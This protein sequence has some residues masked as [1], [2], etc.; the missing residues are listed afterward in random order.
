MPT[1]ALRQLGQDAQARHHGRR[2][3]QLKTA[4]CRTG[5]V[6]D[7]SI[8]VRHAST[9]PR[10]LQG[11]TSAVRLVASSHASPGLLRI[12]AEQANNRRQIRRH[13]PWQPALLAGGSRDLLGRDGRPLLTGAGLARHVQAVHEVVERAPVT[14]DGGQLRGSRAASVGCIIHRVASSVTGRPG[15]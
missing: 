4:G 15:R 5:L 14:Q 9:R 10:Q 1:R 6:A 13:T 3:H 7:Q 8:A 12:P 11:P 2:L